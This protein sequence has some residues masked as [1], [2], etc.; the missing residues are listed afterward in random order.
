MSID[1]SKVTALSD[2]YGAWKQVAD[3]IGRVLWSAAKPVSPEG[4]ILDA[5]D[6]ISS[7]ANIELYS[8]GNWKPFSLT[9]GTAVI[10][11]IVA[12]N[13]DTKPDGSKAAITWVSR[14]VI[15]T[16]IISS[17]GSNAGGWVASEMR[18]WLRGDFYAKLPA[19][20]R[21]VIRTVN[22]TFYDF[23]TKSTLTCEDN[24]WLP[25]KREISGNG[26]NS[27]ADY[28]GYFT[29]ASDRIKYDSSGAAAYWW[30]RTANTS[31]YGTGMWSVVGTD[32]WST[33]GSVAGSFGVVLGFCT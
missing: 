15:T 1:L 16:H 18:T 21:N 7:G 29:S 14:G 13:A 31:A 10:M 23:T 17:S 22:K 9:D 6:V 8:V 30:L 3:A 2:Q 11:E 24:V 26:E 5:W 28:T 20:V 4:E 25:S 33:T 19:E 12:L 27:G 32:G